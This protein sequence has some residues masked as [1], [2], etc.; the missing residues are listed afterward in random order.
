M[1]CCAAV[2]DCSSTKSL[3]VV[4]LIRAASAITLFCVAD[5]RILKREAFCVED[6]RIVFVFAIDVC[7]SELKHTTGGRTMYT[8]RSSEEKQA[9]YAG[10]GAAIPLSTR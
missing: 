8:Q 9:R 7:L 4:S 2:S 1:T 10:A 6:L 5:T 3:I